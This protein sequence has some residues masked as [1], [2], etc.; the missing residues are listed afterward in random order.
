V[1]NYSEVIHIVHIIPYGI[2]GTVENLGAFSSVVKYNE[3]GF[4]FEEEMPNEDFI[5]VHEI[6][7]QH[8]E[9]KDNG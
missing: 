9:D 7:L 5:I 2:H 3:D 1:E 6:V 4:D 8:Y